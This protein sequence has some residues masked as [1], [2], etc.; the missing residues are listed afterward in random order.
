MNEEFESH[1]QRHI[2]RQQYDREVVDA[3]KRKAGRNNMGYKETVMSYGRIKQIARKAV[4]EETTVG[5]VDML[6]LGFEFQA[7]LTWEARQKEVDEAEQRGI[8]K[9]ADEL[10]GLMIKTYDPLA[11]SKYSL[12]LCTDEDKWQAF[13]KSLEGEKE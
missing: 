2:R 11:P 13:L 12:V 1:V 8:Q 3:A 4:S 9:V 5:V 10:R 7:K 6:R